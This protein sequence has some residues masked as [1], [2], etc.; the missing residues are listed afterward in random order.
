MRLSIASLIVAFP[1]F[2]LV[3]IRLERL[4]RQDPSQ[5]NSAIRRW[6]TYLTLVATAFIIAGDLIYALYS[7]LSGELTL[8]FLLKALTIGAIAGSLFWYYLQSLRAD[9]QALSR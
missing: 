6:L 1:L 7:L 4:L 5:R 8:R 2:L 3:A 9:E